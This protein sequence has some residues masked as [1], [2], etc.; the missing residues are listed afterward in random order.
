MIEQVLMI[1]RYAF[2]ILLYLFIFTL[3][4]AV[5][6]DLH[7]FSRGTAARA[8]NLGLIVRGRGDSSN[9]ELGQ[10]F[11]L[12]KQLT[13][14]RYADNDLAIADPHVSAEHAIIRQERGSW[15]IE[16]LG[17]TNGTFLNGKRMKGKKRLQMGDML[18]IGDITFQVVRWENE[19][20]ST[21]RNGL[22]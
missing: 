12:K 8:I 17:S 19:N 4:R 22:S 6:K 11:P 15:Y 5:V 16:D 21:V 2:L 10:F 9:L 18:Q 1:L 3:F 14:G 7:E 13:I 20:S